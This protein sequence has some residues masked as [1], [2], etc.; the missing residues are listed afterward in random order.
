MG[1]FDHQ[2]SVERLFTTDS[3][4]PSAASGIPS[5]TQYR[6]KMKKHTSHPELSTPIEGSR[7]GPI[8]EHSQRRANSPTYEAITLETTK[9]KQATAHGKSKYDKARMQCSHCQDQRN[10][11]SPQGKPNGGWQGNSIL[12]GTHCKECGQ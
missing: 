10:V 2:N 4:D 9:V 11:T 6:D 1:Q 8:R 5:S 12:S 3:S 7:L